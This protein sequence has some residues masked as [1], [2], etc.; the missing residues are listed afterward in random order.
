MPNWVGAHCHCVR[1]GAM[2]SQGEAVRPGA[3]VATILEIDP[4]VER[5]QPARKILDPGNR[6]HGSRTRQREQP[7]DG[8]RRTQD[9]VGVMKE[10]RV[11]RLGQV[12]RLRRR[13][14]QADVLP[15]G[16]I[17][18]GSCPCQHLRTL[19]ETVDPARFADG[20][21]Q[22]R[23]AQAGATGD[24]EDHLSGLQLQRSD[25]ALA[26]WPGRAAGTV[27][28]CGAPAIPGQRTGT[29]DV[30]GERFWRHGRRTE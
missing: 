9:I 7:V 28:A 24:I 1:R 12:Q 27:I 19:V 23:Q 29:H 10:Q 2:R 8:G 30:V 20:G 5:C 17:D 11:D 6:H 15:A 22:Q 13:F 21:T 14:D 3:V 16:G 18:P 25:R 26:D 4:G